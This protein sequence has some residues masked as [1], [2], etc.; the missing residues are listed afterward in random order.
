[1]HSK[2]IQRAMN[3]VTQQHIDDYQR[4]GAVCIRGLLN[5][6]EIDLLQ[7]GIELNLK[8]LSRRTK[9]ASKESDPGFF[10]QDFCNWQINP[11][12]HQFI[13]ETPISIVAGQLMQSKITRLYHDHLLVK[14][15]NT[16][17][18]TPWH[19]DQ[20]YYNIAGMQN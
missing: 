15:P 6:D 5:A 18:I 8:S 11:F 14:E 19:Q 1:M 13:F 3:I 17:Q 9:I 20:P 2:I 16:Q 10:V 12:Y 4:D 7:R